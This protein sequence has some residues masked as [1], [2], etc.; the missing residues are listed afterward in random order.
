MTRTAVYDA[1]ICSTGCANVATM[2]DFKT[3]NEKFRQIYRFS[4]FPEIDNGF[5]ESQHNPFISFIALF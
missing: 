2:L 1:S 3:S 5:L 4:L